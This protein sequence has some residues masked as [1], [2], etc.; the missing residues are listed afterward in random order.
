MKNTNLIYGLLFLVL[1]TGIVFSQ[2]QITLHQLVDSALVN[3]KLIQIKEAQYQE[4]LAVKNELTYKRLPQVTVMGGYTYTLIP[5]K[6]KIDQ[7]ELGF[8]NV[9]PNINPIPLPYNNVVYTF[10]QRHFANAGVL[11]Y[12]PITQQF[13]ISNGEKIHQ[14]DAK[15]AVKEKD[16]VILQIK[17]GIEKLYI[18]LLVNQKRMDEQ[19]YKIQM[20]E[21]D[22][23][24][25]A[26]AYEVNR[27]IA[28]SVDGLT[29][30]LLDE[31]HQLL[32]LEI[33]RSN[34]L[35]ELSSLSTVDMTNNTFTEV[36]FASNS[37]YSLEEALNLAKNNPSYQIAL[38]QIEKSKQAIG[39]SK[40]NY[41]P[42]LGLIGGYFYQY[43]LNNFNA[44]HAVVGL[45][46]KWNITEL[47]TIK[48]QQNQREFLAQ[49][50]NLNSQYQLDEVEKKIKNLYRQLAQAQSLIDLTKNVLEYRK[51]DEAIK[52]H[53]NET[54]LITSYDFLFKKSQR[55]KAEA[56]YYG[57]Q[58]SYNLLITELKI[59]VG[60]L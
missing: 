24:K 32:K 34:Y 60:D 41:L 17:Q 57:A 48:K 31:K 22:L 10:N 1:Q 28:A 20:A 18:A 21:F 59:L 26:N 14:L 49:Q 5:E 39:A 27:T 2:K 50:A 23:N 19:K 35:Q 43:G 33:E 29:A 44:N 37:L 56:D 38:Y 55:A 8:I 47:F 53:E 40:N 7:G 54:G 12:Q 46:L 3:H 42:D 25:A 52:S 4:K 45:N 15:I 6:I 30:T 9:G 51:K 58:L 16:Q 36:D 13:K 11:L